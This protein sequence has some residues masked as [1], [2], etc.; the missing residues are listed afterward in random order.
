[1][2]K[3]LTLKTTDH[4]DEKGF[5][6]SFFC[7]ICGKEWRSPAVPYDT[8]GMTIEHEEARMLLWAKEHSAAFEAANVEAHLQFNECSRC[9]KRVCDECFVIGKGDGDVCKKCC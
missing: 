2:S 3:P 1:M 5:S 6:F 4:S 9:G 8:G 7:D